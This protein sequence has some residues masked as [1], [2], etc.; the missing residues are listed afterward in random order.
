MWSSHRREA[1]LGGRRRVASLEMLRPVE[2][3]TR[4]VRRNKMDDGRFFCFGG[5]G[6][7]WLKH[8]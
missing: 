6:G 8:R 1:L 4:G 3:P 2:G 5:T 7:G